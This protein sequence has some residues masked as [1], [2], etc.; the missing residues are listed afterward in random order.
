MRD[1]C[2]VGPGELQ[3]LAR[4]APG[5]QQLNHHSP[6]F[7]L[8]FLYSHPARCRLRRRFRPT[9][10]WCRTLPSRTRFE[11]CLG[12]CSLRARCRTSSTRQPA[13]PMYVPRCL[14]LPLSVQSHHPSQYISADL[15]SCQHPPRTTS[16]L[17]PRPAVASR[18]SPSSPVSLT[19]TLTLT[20]TPPPSARQPSITHTPTRTPP[21]TPSASSSPDPTSALP[22]SSP[23]SPTPPTRPTHA[24]SPLPP[25]SRT[26]M[27]PSRPSTA[28][29]L[30]S[31]TS[32]L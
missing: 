20:P 8:P 5:G 31:K 29:S 17:C 13:P 12:S 1:P 9:R 3:S 22:S 16:R 27:R 11:T 4:G 32:D 25:G 28:G 7:L 15:L 6:P 26:L 10:L 24:S 21:T 19:F 14:I 18:P 2:V 30:G 23:A